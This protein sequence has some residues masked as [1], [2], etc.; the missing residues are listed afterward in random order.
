MASWNPTPTLG[1]AA[2]AGNSQ[3]TTKNQLLSSV[4]G[5][6]ND[7]D[8]IGLS[9]INVADLK[10]STL[11]VGTWLSAPII[12]VCSLRAQ[13]IDISGVALDPSGVIITNA[14]SANQA[15]FNLQILST[16]EFKQTFNTNIN[17]S[18]DLHVGEAISGALTGL[19]FL[20]FE[21]LLGLGAGIGAALQGLGNGLAAMIWGRGGNTTYIN[22]NNYELLGG[23][24][25]LQ[26]STL[27]NTYPVYSSIMR[28][29]SSSGAGNQVPGQEIFVSTL[30]YPGQICIRS[31]SDPQP[32]MTINSNI[33]TST[34]QQFGE[35]VPLT[36]VDP[37]NLKSD[38]VST[39]AISSGQLYAQ[40]AEFDIARNNGQLVDGTLQVGLFPSGPQY[41]NLALEYQ[42]PIQFRLGAVN[43]ARILGDVNNLWFQSDQPIYFTTPGAPSLANIGGSLAIGSNLGETE[44]TISTLNSSNVFANVGRFSTLI[45]TSLTVISSFSTINN[46]VASNVLSTNL[47]TADLISTNNLQAAYVF[48]YT[49][50]T[51]YGF[52][53]NRFGP[54]SIKRNDSIVSTTYA[55]V[56]SITQNILQSQLNVT[57][58][59][60]TSNAAAPVMSIDPTN[61]E[62]WQSTAIVLNN[63]F[64]YGGIQIADIAQW[65][66][67]T[68]PVKSGTFDLIFDATDPRGLQPYRVT[69]DRDPGLYPSTFIVGAA[70]PQGYYKSY[71]F[72]LPA[73]SNGWWQVQSPAPP[74]YQTTN[75]NAISIWQDINDSY[76]EGTDRL[77]I[78][79]GDIFLEGVTN[80][81]QIGT[82]TAQQLITSNLQTS[83]MS[84]ILFSTSN[85]YISSLSTSVINTGKIIA[86]T[87]GIYGYQSF[88][89]FT[90]S[91][92]AAPTSFPISYRHVINSTDY[93]PTYNI[94][95][96]FQ[97]SNE[98]TSYNWSSWNNTIWNN[99]VKNTTLGE[100]GIYVGDVQTTQGSYAGQFWI[101]NTLTTPLYALT[102]K[103]ITPGGASNVGLIQ[104]GTFGRVYTND[105]QT[106]FIQSNV[107]NPQGITAASFSNTLQMSQTVQQTV[108]TDTQNIQVQAPN[109]NLITGTFNVYA[110][111]IRVNSRR[112]GSA[113]ASGLPSYPIGIENTV[114]VDSDIAWTFS[115]DAWQSDAT[116]V[117]YNID[118]K[119]L[120][121]YNMWIVQVIP[122]RFRTNQSLIYSWDVQPTV[123]AI[124]GSTGYCWAYNRY[125]QVAAGISGPGDGA[126]NWNWVLAIPKNYC[127]YS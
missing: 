82:L 93:I 65:S 97:G 96:P 62:Q 34:M 58:N 69:Q 73:N 23:S 22:N 63:Y 105:G 113:Q 30:F 91:Y 116:N 6:Y 115:N 43:Y 125:I 77:H 42:V 55:Q 46:V 100:P 15:L 95:A 40:I 19:G 92:N 24:T 124:T 2:W 88:T 56:S 35:W 108:I 70:H 79:A 28:L 50:S 99:N 68:A 61:V 60:Q 25:Q 29:V 106:W 121:D 126:N 94:I 8:N 67:V 59:N 49:L 1:G 57:I 84:S 31:V 112:Y 111:Q 122:S 123:I 20:L 39:N 109:T 38:S 75:S 85:A 117:L 78:K 3:L 110:D 26:V 48:P 11:T 71:R 74:P 10:V 101:N 51:G 37:G 5:I 81:P 98:F 36:G 18:L 83:N 119:I 47:I 120:Y 13:A 64:T 52:T 114:Y 90:G 103:A 17:V 44:L 127:T 104:G 66:S 80:F 87:A 32:M 89:N 27:G 12:N 107:P 21:A 41:A 33:N 102:I 7:I 72:T 53:D 86:N 118:G 14:I 16:L 76:I 9:S 45:A 4:T 54:Y